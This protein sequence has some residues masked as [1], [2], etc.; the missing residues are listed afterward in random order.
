MSKGSLLIDFDGTIVDHQFPEIGEPI[1]GA[2]ETLKALKK[3]GWQLILWTCR[4]DM[5]DR[6]YLTEAIEFCKNNGI[7]FDAAN[8]GIPD[9][10]LAIPAN[11]MRK[12]HVTHCID[13]RN[14]FGFPGWNKV[15]KELITLEEAAEL[16]IEELINPIRPDWY[17][18]VGHTAGSSEEELYI[19]LLKKSKAPNIYKET[20][21]LGYPVHVNYVGKVQAN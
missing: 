21:W 15:A 5:P 12:P 8:E 11:V 3:V 7:E 1:E 17:L 9:P 14:L 18:S 2:F 10:D 6:N 20:G 4:E 19:Y 16:L 13:D